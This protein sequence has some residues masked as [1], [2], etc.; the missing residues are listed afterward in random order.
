M[1]V[2]HGAE[3]LRLLESK[4]P[5]LVILDFTLPDTTASELDFT[6][7]IDEFH[8]SDQVSSRINC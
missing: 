6:I 5:D 8:S 1:P 4:R 7:K 3:G 2:G